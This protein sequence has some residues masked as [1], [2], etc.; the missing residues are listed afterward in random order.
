MMKEGNSWWHGNSLKY[1]R[2]VRTDASFKIHRQRDLKR[3][4]GMGKGYSGV[5]PGV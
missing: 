4:K 1:G 3:K 2:K 5:G